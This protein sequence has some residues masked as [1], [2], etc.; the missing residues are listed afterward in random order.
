MGY[1]A[2]G[3]SISDGSRLTDAWHQVGVYVAR[4]L[5]GKK[6]ADLPIVQSTKFEMVI[7]L[8]AAKAL[9]LII[10]NNLLVSA[11]ELIE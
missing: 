8:Q 6:L 9:G 5:N 10:P 2:A 3:G 1:V 7:N 11:D 4:I